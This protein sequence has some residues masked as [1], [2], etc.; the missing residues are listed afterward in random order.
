MS[1]KFVY[2]NLSVD[3]N[4]FLSVFVHRLNTLKGA[5]TSVIQ[6]ISSYLLDWEDQMI[7]AGIEFIISKQVKLVGEIA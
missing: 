6:Q 2:H 7:K 4:S 3:Q 5:G 1:Y